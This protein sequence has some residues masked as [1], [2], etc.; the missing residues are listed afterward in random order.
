MKQPNGTGFVAKFGADKPVDIQYKVEGIHNFR[1]TENNSTMMLNA[2]LSIEFWVNNQQDQALDLSVKNCIFFFDVEYQTDANYL[3]NQ[4]SDVTFGD[5]S[6]D[7]SALGQ[8][9]HAGKEKDNFGLDIKK[10]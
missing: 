10:M 9:P 6:V 5:I 3:F 4:V 1:V 8:G 7:F 2:D